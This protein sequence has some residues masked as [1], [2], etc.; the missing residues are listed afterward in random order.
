MSGRIIDSSISESDKIAS[1]SLKSLALFPFL[2]A[3]LNSH[4][5]MKAE[6]SIIKG[7]V[8]PKIKIFNEKDI[9]KCLLEINNKTNLKWFLHKGL[10]YL[11]SL[12]WKDHQKGLRRL[13]DDLLPDYSRTTPGLLPPEVKEEEEEEEVKKENK[14]EIESILRG[15]FRNV[16]LSDSEISKLEQK[17]GKIETVEKIIDLDLWIERGNKAKNHYA[18]ILAWNR[19]NTPGKDQKPLKSKSTLML[20]QAYEEIEREQNDSQGN[21]RDINLNYSIL[22]ESA[23]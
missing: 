16:C 19:K 1:L 11:H 2:I 22:P 12:N 9:K 8:V 6:P 10:Y 23:S 7:L 13:G 21:E 15:E 14:E 4:G 20:Q 18:T 17:I 3:H 5:K